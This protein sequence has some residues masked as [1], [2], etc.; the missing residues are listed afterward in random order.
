MK[1]NLFII[2]PLLIGCSK[3]PCRSIDYKF[4]TQDGTKYI[5]IIDVDYGATTARSFEIYFFEKD[6]LVEKRRIEVGSGSP[7]F[8]E[9]SDSKIRLLISGNTIIF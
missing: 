1:Y 2:L 4:T 9:I 5:E 6:S 3:D 7:I 8:N